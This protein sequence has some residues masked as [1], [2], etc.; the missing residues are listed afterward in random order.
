MSKAGFKVLE[1]HK[2]NYH[3]V[4]KKGYKSLRLRLV[5]F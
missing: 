5:V 1:E 2:V 4:R 3:D